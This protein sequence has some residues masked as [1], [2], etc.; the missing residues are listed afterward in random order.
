MWHSRFTEVLRAWRSHSSITRDTQDLLSCCCSPLVSRFTQDESQAFTNTC[1][2]VPLSAPDLPGINT[3]PLQTRV[4][5]LLYQKGVMT[6]QAPFKFVTFEVHGVKM[7]LWIFCMCWNP[8]TPNRSLGIIQAN[9][10][11]NQGGHCQVLFAVVNLLFL[12][13]GFLIS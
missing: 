2:S 3:K 1:F 6:F 4:F 5:L 9:L 13:L 7:H 11:M 12:R 10:R 8:L